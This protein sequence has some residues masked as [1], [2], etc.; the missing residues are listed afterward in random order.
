MEFSAFKDSSMMVCAYT[1][2]EKQ[3]SIEFQK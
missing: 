2:E 3:V 1:G